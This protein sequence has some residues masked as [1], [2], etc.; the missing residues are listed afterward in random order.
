MEPSVFAGHSLGEYSALVASEKLDFARGARLV[1]KRGEAMDSLAPKGVGGMLA[2]VGYDG[3]SLA[4]LCQEISEEKKQVLE[5]ANYNSK[6]QQILS[7]HSEAIQLAQQ[8]LAD[9]GVR[10]IPL[11]VSAPFHCSLMKPAARKMEKNIIK[12]KFYDPSV[13]IVSN[14][15][16]QATSNSDNIKKLLIEQIFSKVRWR[17]S[18][19][20]MISNGVKEFIEVGPGKVLSGLI[21]RI[22]DKVSSR[23][24]NTI[25]EIKNLK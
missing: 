21:K 7:G 19:E 4:G 23:S 10:V 24:V 3:Q 20:Y 6:S 2:V 16:A 17:E 1:K 18:V 5:V 9:Q 8:K 14:V 25:E 22:N 15:T 11:P 12:T 13:Q